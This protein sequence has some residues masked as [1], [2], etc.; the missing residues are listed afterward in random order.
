[1]G[2]FCEVPLAFA[3]DDEGRGLAGLILEVGQQRGDGVELDAID[4]EDLVVGLE[5]SLSGGHGG[6]E[7]ADLH[8]RVLHFGDEA[9]L[10]EV[11][12]VGATLGFDEEFGI[13]ALAV[14]DEGE[15]DGLVEVQHAAVE[16]IFPGGVLDGVEANDEITRLN[17][18]FGGWGFGLDVVGDGG[19]VEELLDLVVHHEDG[20]HEAEGE[21]EVGDGAGE[22]DKD[23]LPA[24][25]VVEVAGVVV[26][27]FGLVG[28]VGG[29]SHL[30]GHL[31][32]A[33]EGDGGDLVL[34]FAAAEAEEAFAEA[35]GEDLDTD[36][37]EL[38][39]GEVAKFV[40]QNH[41]AKDD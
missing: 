20:G 15:R 30:S 10:F 12:V 25:M 5:A 7:R 33:A 29:E 3:L 8:R 41:D 1:M 21:D 19:A 27:G 9:D 40:D 36:A 17:A 22:G 35:D 6:L 16:D 39:D 11:E 32:V 34:G 2:M 18:G 28:I 26:G 37:A 31:D 24:G 23:A 4:G 14:V 13:G 38:G